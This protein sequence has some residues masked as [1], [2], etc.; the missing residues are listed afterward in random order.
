M[1][2]LVVLSASFGLDSA[3]FATHFAALTELQRWDGKKFLQ[4]ISLFQSGDCRRTG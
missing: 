1:L 4:T 2:K 3:T